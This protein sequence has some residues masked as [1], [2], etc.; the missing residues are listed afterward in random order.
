MTYKP[1]PE[2][3]T[4]RVSKVQGLGLFATR[5]IPKGTVLGVSHIRNKAFENGYIRTPLGGFIN[6]SEWPNSELIRH[7]QGY[8]LKTLVTIIIGE[9]IT[10][11]YHL[12]DIEEE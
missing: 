5:P 12:Y 9:E 3:L 2:T 8:V 4:I 10:T 11:K 1:L 7:N 6:H